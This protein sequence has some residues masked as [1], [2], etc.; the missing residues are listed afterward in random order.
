MSH[1][2]CLHLTSRL[3]H[4]SNL[5]S[6]PDPPEGVFRDYFYAFLDGLDDPD[7]DLVLSNVP[8]SLQNK[9][10]IWFFKELIAAIKL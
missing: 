2:T 7:A 9:N 1:M 10:A 3:R 6:D 4:G 5:D 8:E